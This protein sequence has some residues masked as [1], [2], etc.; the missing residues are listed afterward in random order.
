[1]APQLIES[2]HQILLHLIILHRMI[3][4]PSKGGDT[5]VEAVELHHAA[6]PESI[7]LMH[8][9]RPHSHRESC[10]KNE[11]KREGVYEG[12]REREGGRQ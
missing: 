1:M 10:T 5:G 12:E 2:L 11:G 7:P 6:V 8:G 9:Q 4:H 3:L